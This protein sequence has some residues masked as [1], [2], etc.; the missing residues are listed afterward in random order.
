MEYTR[1]VVIT[2]GMIFQTDL[3][4]DAKAFADAC[5]WGRVAFVEFPDKETF[6]YAIE[7]VLAANAHLMGV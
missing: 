7:S 5:D 6:D 3:E 1:F 2:D 4:Q